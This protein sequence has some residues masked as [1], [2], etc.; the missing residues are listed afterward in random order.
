MI[1]YTISFFG[2]FVAFLLA[3]F[4][5]SVASDFGW[6]GVVVGRMVVIVGVVEWLVGGF[7]LVGAVNLF[8][9]SCLRVSFAVN[10][11]LVWVLAS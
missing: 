7:A 1:K 5:G 4:R 9:G 2:L 6:F 3:T 8:R 11:A 10:D